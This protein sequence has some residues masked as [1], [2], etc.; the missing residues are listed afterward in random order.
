MDL[1]KAFTR[2]WI[3]R[4]DSLLDGSWE[5]IHSWMDLEKG[6]TSGWISLLFV[7]IVIDIER[8]SEA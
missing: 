4:R 8:H 7:C 1:E 6:F 2:G 5:G 3:L